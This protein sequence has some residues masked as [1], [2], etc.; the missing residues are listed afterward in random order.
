MNLQVKLLGVLQE[1]EVVRLGGD[2]IINV[3]FRV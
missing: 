3:D 2:S 1:R